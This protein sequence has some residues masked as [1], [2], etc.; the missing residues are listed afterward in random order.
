M[1]LLDSWV[2]G[3]IYIGQRTNKNYLVKQ[4]CM[5][6][7]NNTNG[8][9]IAM[10]QQ[11]VFV[12]CHYNTTYNQHKQCEILYMSFDDERETKEKWTNLILRFCKFVFLLLRKW[13]R[14]NCK[15][16]FGIRNLIKAMKS[17]TIIFCKH[18]TIYNSVMRLH[19][20]YALSHFC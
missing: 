15:L 5:S 16:Q 6:H 18:S 19:W 13:M 20:V 4:V 7:V 3:F 2:T 17:S 10:Q 14:M 12:I 8:T 11:H 1:T 9:T